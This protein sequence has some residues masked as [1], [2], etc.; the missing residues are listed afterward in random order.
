MRV[1]WR[2]GREE[3]EEQEDDDF[4]NFSVLKHQEFHQ[5]CIPSVE[6]SP[7]SCCSNRSNIKVQATKLFLDCTT[8]KNFSPPRQ[9]QWMSRGNGAKLSTDSRYAI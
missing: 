9:S 2:E 3:G 5:F 7:F 8:G 1:G 6:V 4:S